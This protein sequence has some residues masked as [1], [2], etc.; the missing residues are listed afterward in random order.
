[1]N[2]D[3]EKEDAYQRSLSPQKRLEYWHAVREGMH[4]HPDCRC[5]QCKHFCVMPGGFM[6]YDIEAP[7]CALTESNVSP[8]AVYFDGAPCKDF[9]PFDA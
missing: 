4:R 6:P 1:M 7:V 2:P 9:V 8:A 5:S 3:Y